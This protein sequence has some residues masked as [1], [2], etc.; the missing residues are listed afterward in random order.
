[1]VKS[2]T[3]KPD[4]DENL[5]ALYNLRRSWAFFALLSA[6]YVAA[7]WLLLRTAWLPRAG[8]QWA[9]LAALIALYLL[10]VLWR[11]LEQNYRPGEVTLLARFG[12]GNWMTLLR[13]LLIAGLAGFLFLPRPPGWLAWI[14]AILYT[15]AIAADSLDGYLARRSNYA[16]RLG[17]ILDISFDGLGVLAAAILLIQYGQVPAWY[18]LVALARYLFLFGEWLLPRFGRPVQPLAPSGQRR[19]FASIQFVFI[20]VLLYPIFPPQLTKIAASFFAV[21]FLIGFCIDFLKVSGAWRQEESQRIP[22]KFIAIIQIVVRLGLALIGVF[23]LVQSR[24]IIG[25]DPLGIALLFLQL[26]MAIFVLFGIAGRISSGIA[27]GLI[28]FGQ[29][30][31][32]PT[33]LQ[34]IQIAGYIAIIYMGSGPYSLWSPEEAWYYPSAKLMRSKSGQELSHETLPQTY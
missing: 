11:N 18:I 20:A 25:V 6:A 1:M 27:L 22:S 23:S 32:P 29:W 7:G 34:I 17:S 28:G 9:A 8:L 13:G 2:P 30:Y 24:F 12:S 19:I 33:M 10:I 4:T 21:P 3:M 15:L 14:P 26:L 5:Q 31:F 16:T